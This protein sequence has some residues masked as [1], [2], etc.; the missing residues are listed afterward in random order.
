MYYYQPGARYAHALN[1]AFFG[2]NLAGLVLVV[3]LATVTLMRL[4]RRFLPNGQDRPFLL[5]WLLPILPVIDQMVVGY[6]LS[7][8]IRTGATYTTVFENG[9]YGLGVEKIAMCRDIPGRELPL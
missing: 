7:T 9:F 2:P 3:P 4:S 1:L 5:L 8:P 6:G